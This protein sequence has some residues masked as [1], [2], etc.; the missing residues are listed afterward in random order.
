M[1]FSRSLSAAYADMP[2]IGMSQVCGSF[3]RR[4]TASQRSSSGIS[5]SIRITSGFSLEG[6]PAALLAVLR[7][8][9]LEAAAQLR[10][11]SS[12]DEPLLHRRDAELAAKT[13]QPIR[14]NL[15]RARKIISESGFSGLFEALKKGVALPM[16]AFA[17]LVE[18]LQ[19][20]ENRSAE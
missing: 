1:A 8:E 14:A 17:P 10:A 15:Q 4:R 13:G 20:E 3:L 2:M 11:F 6:Q 7:C 18:L 9:N 16:A 5:S 19:Q 12:I